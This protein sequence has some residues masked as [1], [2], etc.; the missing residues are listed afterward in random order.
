[1][2]TFL[3][4]LAVDCE[5]SGEADDIACDCSDDVAEDGGDEDRYC[6]VYEVIEAPANVKEIIGNRRLH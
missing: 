1:M 5:D 3:I 2:K 4:T 6:F